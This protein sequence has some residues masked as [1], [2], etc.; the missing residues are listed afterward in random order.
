MIMIINE[1]RARSIA[2]GWISPS[3]HD[4]NLTAFATGHPRWT[5]QGLL[6]E[7]TRNIIAVR[8]SPMHYD[9]A[10]ECLRELRQLRDWAVSVH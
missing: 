10:D 9:D 7:V 5:A 3:P 2:A 8:R 6:S 4:A 1:T